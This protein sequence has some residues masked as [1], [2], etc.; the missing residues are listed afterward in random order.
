MSYVLP[1]RVAIGEVDAWTVMP[2]HTFDSD[3]VYVLRAVYTGVALTRGEDLLLF[4]RAGG[5]GQNH[6][7]DVRAVGAW[8][9]P[10]A[11]A[12]TWGVDIVFTYAGPKAIAIPFVG[13]NASSMAKNVVADEDLRA[14]FPSIA[15]TAEEPVFGRLSAPADAIDTWRAQ[16]L[17]WDHNLSGKKGRG[18]P[19]ATFAKPTDLSLFHGRADEGRAVTPWKVT[20]TPVGPQTGTGWGTTLWLLAGLGL[21]GAAI[22]WTTT[23]RRT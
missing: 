20:T 23:R 10:G 21:A 14:A 9:P 1:R 17:L 4:A 2:A 11:P 3:E 16:P 8:Q 6:D 19:T 15:L 22:A 12:D 18:G 7:L 13:D 5:Q